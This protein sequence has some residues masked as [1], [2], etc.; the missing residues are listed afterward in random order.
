LSFSYQQFFR[1][2][3]PWSPVEAAQDSSDGVVWPSGCLQDNRR[4]PSG[5]SGSNG[6]V[7]RQKATPKS[8]ATEQRGKSGGGGKR[9]AAPAELAPILKRLH[10]TDEG[11]LRLVADFSRLFRRRAGTPTSLR[12][13][14]DKLG[15]RR[16]AGIS[17]SRALFV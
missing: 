13:D 14:A 12:H 10:V 4:V 8:G 7:R 9:R 5:A 15:R 11:W 1:P 6:R 17:H 16:K 3:I 2:A